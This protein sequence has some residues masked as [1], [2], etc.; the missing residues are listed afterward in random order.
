MSANVY[1]VVY[2][3]GSMFPLVSDGVG[4]KTKF[5][6]MFVHECLHTTSCL[7]L[8]FTVFCFLGEVTR[9]IRQLCGYNDSKMKLL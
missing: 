1:K 6:V 7:W 8:R 9:L 5:Q 3:V 2:R 4:N